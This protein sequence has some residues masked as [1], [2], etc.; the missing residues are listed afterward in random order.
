MVSTKL[1]SYNAS[2]IL[3]QMFP[4]DANKNHDVNDTF[5]LGIKQTQIYNFYN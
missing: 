2:Y 3:K 5:T 1:L 4:I